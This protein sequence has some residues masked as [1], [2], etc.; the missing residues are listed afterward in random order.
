MARP[1][2]HSVAFSMCTYFFCVS[3]IFFTPHRISIARDW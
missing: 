1:V 2:A 3:P